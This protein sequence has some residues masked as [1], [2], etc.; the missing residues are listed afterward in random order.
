[1]IISMF[2]PMHQF[3][4]LAIGFYLPM[5]AIGYSLVYAFS[6]KQRVKTRR[7]NSNRDAINANR[8]TVPSFLEEDA[9][10]QQ[11]MLPHHDRSADTET[12]LYDELGLRKS[13]VNNRAGGDE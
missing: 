10:G 4:V 9:S 5:S 12:L 6:Q 2:S 7:L 3:L 8:S 13:E 11:L 1:M